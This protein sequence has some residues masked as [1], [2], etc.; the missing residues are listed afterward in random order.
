VLLEDEGGFEE[1]DVH[2]LFHKVFGEI[3]AWPGII[4]EF[5]RAE[6]RELAAGFGQLD[7]L[8]AQFAQP[9]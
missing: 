7:D 3:L 6:D 2:E 4:D 1:V 8:G 5:F 9:A